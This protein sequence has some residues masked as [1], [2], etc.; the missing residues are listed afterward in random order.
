MDRVILRDDIVTRPDETREFSAG[1]QAFI[2]DMDR[3]M[4]AVHGNLTFGVSN[5]RR[6]YDVANLPTKVCSHD[7]FEYHIRPVLESI[8]K[9][10]GLGS[11]DTGY[12]LDGVRDLSWWLWNLD[13]SPAA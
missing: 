5:S 7:H 3:Y 4:R 10:Y 8:A 6:A 13:G 12:G 1:Q 9:R 11:P 2:D